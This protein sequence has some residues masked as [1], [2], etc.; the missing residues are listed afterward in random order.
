MMTP[1]EI[2]NNY[3]N[4]FL[5]KPYIWGGDDPIK[6]VDCSGLVV[7]LLKASGMLTN[8]EDLSSS[9]L[10]QRY[11]EYKVFSPAFGTLSFYG[12]SID[13]IKH[14][15]FCVDKD[16]M[17]EAGG[18]DRTV[19]NQKDAIQKNAFVRIRPI[20][21]RSD[22]VAFVHPPYFWERIRWKK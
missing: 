5:G 6:G 4:S 8:S 9:G 21:A 7:E 13:S 14:V 18:G 17:I 16:L 12:S 2:I 1:I 22:F 15:G 11:E 20:K 19:K 10:Y 3:A